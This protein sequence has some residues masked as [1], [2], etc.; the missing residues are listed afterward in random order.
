MS[1]ERA[2][3]TLTGP[4]KAAILLTVIGEE[5]AA[6]I[7]RQLSSSDMQQIAAELASLDAIPPELATT[8]YRPAIR[9]SGRRRLHDPP[10]E[11]SI[12]RGERQGPCAKVHPDQAK[13]CR[14]ARLAAKYRSHAARGGSGEGTSSDYR[15]DRCAPGTATCIAH[16]FASAQR[17]SD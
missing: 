12:R 7:C 11:K 2:K 10:A 15:P 4:R 17:T 13:R 8:G 1:G 16:S 6:V 3:S 14:Q 5:A 9:S